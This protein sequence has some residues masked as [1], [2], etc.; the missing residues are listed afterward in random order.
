V[1]RNIKEVVVE[2]ITNGR[3]IEKLKKRA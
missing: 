1:K 2:R 3:V